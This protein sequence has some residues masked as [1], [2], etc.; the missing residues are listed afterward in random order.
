MNVQPLQVTRPTTDSSRA[1]H[2]R[3]L[4]R[5][6]H[7]ERN[8]HRDIRHIV[9][10]AAIH[11][12]DGQHVSMERAENR[13]VRRHLAVRGRREVGADV[14][15]HFQVVHVE[16]DFPRRRREAVEGCCDSRQLEPRVSHS[17]TGS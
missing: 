7:L 4:R 9:P 12:R 3:Q 10:D 14:E 5:R 2:V 13:V 16:A 8:H 17:L 6:R 15:R 1:Q 11:Q